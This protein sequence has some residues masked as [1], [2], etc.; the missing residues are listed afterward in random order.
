MRRWW[1]YKTATGRRPVKEFIEKLDD[2]DVAAIMDAMREVKIKGLAVARHLDGDIY[3][4]RA[5][6]NR[7]IYRV[8]FAPQGKRS[9][10]LLALEAFKKKSQ[11]TPPQAIKLARQR[12]R[13]WESR[14]RKRRKMALSYF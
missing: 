7:V 5:N 1:D 14:G 10:V 9:Q 3:E 13:D 2:D 8:L 11:K 12:L 4:V 6:G